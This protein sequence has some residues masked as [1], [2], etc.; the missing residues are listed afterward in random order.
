[1]T[2]KERIK[3]FSELGHVLRISA[4]RGS[5]AYTHH[6]EK[7]IN[8]QQFNNPWFTPDN[9]RMAIKAIAMEL[10]EKNLKKWT[11][12][13]P[14]LEGKGK[15]GSVA[16]VMAGNIPLAGFHDYLSV[17]ISGFDLMAKTSSK[18]PELIV[19][20]HKILSEIN[21]EFSQK[22]TFAEGPI[23]GFDY[24]IATGSDNSSRYFEYYFGKYPHIIRKNRNS[25]ALIE[26]DETDH[27]LKM[28][29]SD[30]FSYFGLGCRNVSKIYIPEEYDLSRIISI[31]KDYSKMTDHHKYANNYDFNK[32][33]YLVNQDKFID[34]GFLLMK[35]DKEISSPVAVLYFEYYKSFE[36]VLRKT[37]SMK[38]KIQCIV[39]KRS[40][41]FGEAQMPHLWDYADGVDTLEFLLK[42][43]YAGII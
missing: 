23:S 18:D 17:L 5:S 19:V 39:N 22:V 15:R 43:N 6:L 11:D 37:E 10:T 30:V 2:L 26:G 13:Y 34:T 4:E 41:P 9:V 12:K 28:L 33:V 31:W 40:V 3:A 35:Q 29:G 14:D 8:N 16:V 1:M 21:T 32:A 24:V 25:I 20:V 27:D 36:S 42:K 7:V 38:D